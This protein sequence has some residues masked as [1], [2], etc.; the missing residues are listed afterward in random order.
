MNADGSSIK[1]LT[2]HTSEDAQPS[3]SPDGNKI[4]FYSDRTGQNE[5]YI[6]NSDASNVKRLTY[7]ESNSVHPCFAGKPR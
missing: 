1:R 7:L 2:S 3:F 4:V 5:I 6:M